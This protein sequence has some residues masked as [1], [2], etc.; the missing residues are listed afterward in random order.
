MKKKANQVEGIVRV[1]TIVQVALSNVD[2]IK[3]DSENLTL[4]VVEEV[5]DK[6]KAP[7]KYRLA[8]EKGQL[9]NLYARSYVK[10]I[11]NTNPSLMG[12]QEANDF[13]Q[14][15]SIITERQA[16][17]STS[18]VGGQGLVRCHCTTQCNTKR[19]KCKKANRF[20]NSRCHKG[21]K[22]CCNYDH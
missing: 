12:L 14:G 16:A 8:C 22:K 21:N 15:L 18:I 13:W 5:N 19:C 4:L 7:T 17:R 9:K 3:V 11:P 1:G 20:C 6:G 2:R 10:H